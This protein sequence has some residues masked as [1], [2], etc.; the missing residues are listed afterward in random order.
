MPNLGCCLPRLGMLSV[1]NVY[2]LV[3]AGVDVDA[4]LAE[5]GMT[6]LGLGPAVHLVRLAHQA[7]GAGIL[8]AFTLVMTHGDVLVKDGIEGAPGAGSSRSSSQPGTGSWRSPH[9]WKR[10]PSATPLEWLP[11]KSR[12]LYPIELPPGPFR[13]YPAGTV[14]NRP[15]P[16]QKKPCA[17]GARRRHGGHTLGFTGRGHGG[18]SDPHTW[19]STI[20][21]SCG[22]CA[23]QSGAFDTSVSRDTFVGACGGRTTRCVCVRRRPGQGS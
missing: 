23:V 21:T 19:P 2:T 17:K 14:S 8:G 18:P 12:A 1:V 13:G 15:S 20:A 11:E 7:A 9:K 3:L 10:H 4:D 6:E 22:G 5:T 16:P